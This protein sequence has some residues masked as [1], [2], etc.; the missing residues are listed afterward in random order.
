MGAKK[1]NIPWNKNK[2]ILDVLRIKERYPFFYKIEKPIE[3]DNDL[4]VKCKFCKEYF[5]P[6]GSQLSERVRCLEKEGNY[7]E[8]HFYCSKECKQNCPTYRSKPIL[9]IKRNYPLE[10]QLMVFRKTVLERDNYKCRYCGE[11]A[12]RVHHIYPIKR[13]PEFSLDPENGL[14]ICVDCHKTYPHRD[15]C[16]YY[17]IAY[18]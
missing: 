13:C 12:A 5:I 10:S 16:S 9:N 8:Q 17:K 2:R 1:G 4:Y 3:K 7:G 15:D 14:S 6:T 18:G 11:T